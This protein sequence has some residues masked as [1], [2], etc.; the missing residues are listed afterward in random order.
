MDHRVSSFL[1]WMM[2]AVFY[3][4]IRPLV[5]V[6]PKNKKAWI[7]CSSPHFFV[8]HFLHFAKRKRAYSSNLSKPLI[9]LVGTVRFEL[10]TST[11]SVSIILKTLNNEKRQ[12]IIN[13]KR[14]RALFVSRITSLSGVPVCYGS[15][16]VAG[17]G[18]LADG[19]FIRII[20]NSLQHGGQFFRIVLPT[21][22][23]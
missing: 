13:H 14:Y 16:M 21:P 1:T 19:G 12:E 6:S 9:S 18:Y 10:T 3:R 20:Y 11:V 22:T 5:P 23:V 2:A 8:L 4:G 15:R 17:G 7:T